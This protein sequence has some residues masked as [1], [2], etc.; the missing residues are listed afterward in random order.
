MSKLSKLTSDMSSLKMVE[1]ERNIIIFNILFRNRNFCRN[2]LKFPLKYLLPIRE[3]PSWNLGPVA[4]Y[5][6]WRM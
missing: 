6:D 1:C 2:I 3:L 5:S 4:E